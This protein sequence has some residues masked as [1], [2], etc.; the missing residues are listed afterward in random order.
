M[1]FPATS[2]TVVAEVVAGIVGVGD[3]V[4]LVARGG[5]YTV[6]P[7]HAASAPV[8]PAQTNQAT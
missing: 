1:E 7:E 2:G 6:L 5:V 8:K 4:T 3:A